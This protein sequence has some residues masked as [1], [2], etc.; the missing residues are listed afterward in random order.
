M[1]ILGVKIPLPEIKIP[2]GL[3]V[4][5]GLANFLNSLKTPESGRRDPYMAYRF[6]VEFMGVI[7]AGFSEV[8]G[9]NVET[10]IEEVAEG[11]LNHYVHKLPKGS[12]YSNIT[13]KRGMV[14]AS[15]WTWY[16]STIYG[17]IVRSAISV[18]LLDHSGEIAMRWDFG[19]VYPV[20][21]SGPTLSA[22]SNSVAF[23]SIELA[24]NGLL[25]FNKLVG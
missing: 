4:I 10:G 17:K 25:G 23:E 14:D 20:K 1:K 13:L 16:N 3:P 11:G 7:K 12:K 8:S 2:T 18:C 19:G 9:L 5:G 15:L 24:H 6:V 22:T 21:W